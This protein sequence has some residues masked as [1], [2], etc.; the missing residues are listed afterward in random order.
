MSSCLIW[1]GINCLRRCS[2]PPLARPGQNVRLWDPLHESHEGGVTNFYYGFAKVYLYNGN[3]HINTLSLPL[4]YCKGKHCIHYLQSRNSSACASWF[5][6]Y[7]LPFK[8]DQKKEKGERKKP[9]VCIIHP[10]SIKPGLGPHIFDN[11]L[12]SFINSSWSSCTVVNTSKKCD[13]LCSLPTVLPVSK[14]QIIIERGELL[15]LKRWNMQTSSTVCETSGWRHTWRLSSDWSDDWSVNG[16]GGF[17]CIQ[18]SHA[19]TVMS[20]SSIT[21]WETPHHLTC[22]VKD[23]LAHHQIQFWTRMTEV[24]SSLAAD[25]KI[26]YTWMWERPLNTNTRSKIEADKWL[27]FPGYLMC[28]FN[29]NV[30]SCPNN[31]EKPL[32]FGANSRRKCEDWRGWR[33]ETGTGTEMRQKATEALTLWRRY[34]HIRGNKGYKSRPPASEPT[35]LFGVM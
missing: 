16:G 21:S 11:Y 7:T 4:E 34:K 32:E 10:V 17:H 18:I 23:V 29:I 30:I 2:T 31:P 12:C 33:V 6:G 25:N 35:K 15:L 19:L 22:R 13:C 28:I 5:Q 1:V 9:T 3:T 26:T 8:C 24:S 20:R 27:A 14:S